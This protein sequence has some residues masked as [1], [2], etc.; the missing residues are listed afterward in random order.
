LSDRDNSILVFRLLVKA[1][2][3]TFQD[4]S[5]NAF[6]KAVRISNRIH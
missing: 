3:H 2:L 6:K 5:I 1:I 4:Q